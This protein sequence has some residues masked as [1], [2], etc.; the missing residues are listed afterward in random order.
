MFTSPETL[1]ACSDDI[2]DHP[3]ASLPKLKDGLSKK[4]VGLTDERAC[5]PNRRAAQQTQHLPLLA[6]GADEDPERRREPI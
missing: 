3:A 4:N 1:Q 2:T 6:L 5:N